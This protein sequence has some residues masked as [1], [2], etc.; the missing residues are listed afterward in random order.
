MKKISLLVAT[1]LLGSSFAIA[2]NRPGATTLN[3]SEAYYHFAEKRHLVNNGLPNVAVDYNF[4]E[5]WAIEGGV[6]FV[7]SQQKH[8]NERSVHGYLYTVD[9]IYRFTPRGSLEPYAIV[10]IGVLSLT[11]NGEDSSHHGN[12]NAGLGSQWFVD[13]SVAFRGELRDFY[14]MRGGKNDVM[15]NVGV[16]FLMGGDS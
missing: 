2:S 15:A 5:R 4:D 7:D 11:Q 13:R 14:T 3:L 1:A 10:G 12:V 8:F 9:G 16:S 6:G